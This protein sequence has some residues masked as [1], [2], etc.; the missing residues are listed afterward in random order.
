MIKSVIYSASN[1]TVQGNYFA[2]NRQ[3]NE[4]VQSHKK[5]LDLK[6]EPLPE[7]PNDFGM[8]MMK[9]IDRLQ[10]EVQTWQILSA[11][12]AMNKADRLIR[13]EDIDRK[14]KANL[15]K[16]LDLTFTIDRKEYTLN[17]NSLDSNNLSLSDI[18]KLE[19]E[20]H[21]NF[22]NML[23]ES[24]LSA[25]DFFKRK[26]T[27][28]ILAGNLN[29]IQKQIT[30]KLN[31]DLKELTDYDNLLY[32]LTILS[33]DPTNYYKS[34]RYF[35]KDNPEIVPITAQQLGSRLA[36]TAHSPIF[37]TAF[38]HLSEYIDLNH[39]NITENVVHMNG[40]G[41]AGKTEA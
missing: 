24:G 7:L 39:L 23:N 14:I 3:I 26:N 8:L 15:L 30:S 21:D 5:D 13:I 40:V 41:G 27:W 19:K 35:I 12:G 18:F 17:P 37:K 16:E 34:L 29:K 25:E 6:W 32:L 33:D 22:I 20:I 38:K 31:E 36:Q 4:F 9:E 28:E 2:H 11:N 1:P 10:Q